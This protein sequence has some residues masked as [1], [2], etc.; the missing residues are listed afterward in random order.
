MKKAQPF[1]IKLILIFAI[2]LFPALCG[3]FL[4]HYRDH[5]QFKTLNRGTLISPAVQDSDLQVNN[6]PQKLWQIVYAPNGCCDAQCQK[7]MYTLHQLRKVLGKDGKR[8]ALTLV[9]PQAC[10]KTDSHDFNKIEFNQANY[11]RLQNILTEQHKTV[12]PDNKIYLIDPLN[13]VFMYYS[14][15][16]DAMNI[17]KD[18][19]RVLEVSQIG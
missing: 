17:L 3:W 9:I 13:N 12:S 16:V 10:S 18:M 14:S 7:T 5:F 11:T 2:S 4:F 1:P 8:V 19:K 6:N 15:T